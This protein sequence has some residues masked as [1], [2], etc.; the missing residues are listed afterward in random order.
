MTSVPSADS[1]QPWHPPS[2]IRI[3][4]ECKNKPSTPSYALWRHVWLVMGSFM[5]TKH[6]CVLIHIWT[7]SEVG[8]PWNR[9][10]PS[11]KIFLK[12]VPRRC[13]F[14][15]SFI[16]FL[17]C[18][19]FAFV[20]VCLLMPCGHLLGKGWLPGLRLW[21]LFVKLSLSHW[22]P[23]SGL[24]LDCID[25]WSLPFLLLWYTDYLSLRWVHSVLSVVLPLTCIFIIIRGIIKQFSPPC[26]SGYQGIKI[27]SLL[28]N[29][30]S[31]QGNALSPSLLELS[32]PFKIEGL[33]LVHQ[34]LVYCLYDA[35]IAS[36]LW[37]T[38]MGFQF[39]E[40]KE[41]RKSHIRRIWGWGRIL[42]STF[43]RSSHDNLWRVG[44]GV[45]LQEKT[46]SNQVS[47]PLSC[48]FLA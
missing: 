40:Q 15:G 34:V 11:S 33:F 29:L 48:D 19:C 18:F 43:S 46:T 25:S 6:L 9:F 8:A 13:F 21:Y 31:L 23:G 30:I 16:L 4:T 20:C 17:S 41:V 7:K 36:I 22:Y 2:L 27:W 1:A 12:T 44:R 42:R 28:F 47:S 26:T 35:L 39:W 37:T 3:Y 24:V 10:K 45:V 32:Y 14:C 5:Q 38:K